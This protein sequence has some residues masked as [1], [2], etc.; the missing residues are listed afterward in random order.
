MNLLEK[1]TIMHYHRHRITEFDLGTAKALGWRNELSQS[2]RFE[3]LARIGDFH[4]CSVLDVGCGQCDL[5]S[6]LDQH[7]RE[8]DYIGIDQMP[9]FIEHARE[10]FAGARN[11]VFFQSDFSQE[12]L[13]EVDY[14]IASG[15]LGY[16]CDQPDY[17]RAMLCKFYAA[18]RRGLA[19]NMLDVE[20]FP[21]HSLLVG[22]NRLAVLEFCRTLSPRVELI[23]GYLGDDF[24]IFIYRD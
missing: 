11:A 23:T 3:V 2:V 19:F 14:V 5:K 9:E 13:P 20:T 4:H 1:A 6:Y 21:G 7:E 8:Y 24:S 15:A 10:R 17:Y 12:E 18:A 22:H 16:R